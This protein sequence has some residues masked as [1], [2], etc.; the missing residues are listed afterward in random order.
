MLLAFQLRITPEEVGTSFPRKKGERLP[1]R[2][3]SLLIRVTTKILETNPLLA[4]L[5]QNE[6][7]KIG[8]WHVSVIWCILFRSK[9]KRLESVFVKSTSFLRNSSTW[10]G[11]EEG[12]VSFDLICYRRQI[13][14]D[15]FKMQTKLTDSSHHELHT[16]E[17]LYFATGTRWTAS[18]VDGYIYVASKGALCE[19]SSRKSEGSH[20]SDLHLFHVSVTRSHCAQHRLKSPNI[21]SGLL[22][23][24]REGYG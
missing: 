21:C 7:T 22:W 23:R 20:L 16:I 8:I 17:I 19:S 11:K 1:Y 5:T 14:T 15:S 10:I 9:T 4:Y 2:I 3:Y 12:A 6:G 18:S 24:P 13:T